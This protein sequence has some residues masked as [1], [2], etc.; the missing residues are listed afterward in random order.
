MNPPTMFC[1]A[2]DSLCRRRCVGLSII[3]GILEI[4]QEEANKLE[5]LSNSADQPPMGSF[6]SNAQFFCT[7][8]SC[9]LENKSYIHKLLAGAPRGAHLR[10]TMVTRS[11]RFLL[12]LALTHVVAAAFSPQ[13]PQ[14]YGTTLDELRHHNSIVT[15]KSEA[16]GSAGGERVDDSIRGLMLNFSKAASLHEK[17]ETVD[18]TTDEAGII[19]RVRAVNMEAGTVGKADDLTLENGSSEAAF[20][21]TNFMTPASRG[22]PDFSTIRGSGA[23]VDESTGLGDRNVLNGLDRGYGYKLD[24]LLAQGLSQTGKPEALPFSEAAKFTE[25]FIGSSVEALRELSLPASVKYAH[26]LP[27]TYTVLALMPSG[28]KSSEVY[29]HGSRSLTAP[30]TS[31]S[32]YSTTSTTFCGKYAYTHSTRYS[33]RYSYTYSVKYS[34]TYSYRYS[35]TYSTRYSYRY[36]YT[37]GYSYSYTYAYTS[38]YTYSYTCSYTYSYRYSY[39]YRYTYYYTCSYRYSYSCSCGKGCTRTCYGT[40]YSTCSG[41]GYGTAYATGYATRYYTCYGR[42]YYTAYATGYGTR[43]A[44]GYGTRYATKYNTAYATAYRTGYATKYVTAYATAYAIKYSTAYAT[45]TC[46]VCYCAA[47]YYS[48]PDGIAAAT[49]TC[50]SCPSG[51][52]NTGE[53]NTDC[54]SCPSGQYQDSSAE[55]SCKTC[56]G[57]STSLNEYRYDKI[58]SLSQSLRCFWFLFV[59]SGLLL[60]NRFS[61]RKLVSDR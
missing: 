46:S 54:N 31:S 40:R 36:S 48:S 57:V 1:M 50:S 23:D 7:G 12:F 55:T 30:S 59:A 5:H 24:A 60:P 43:Y 45:A 33:Y 4:C 16:V 61:E 52:Y 11:Q 51:Q 47:G 49:G 28:K 8:L 20:S 35:Y 21:Q 2:F 26:D 39:T 19:K 6:Y 27:S 56:P 32:C 14:L 29:T 3:R 22:L 42:R 34:Y 9:F 25:N 10:S 18:R 38:Y 58:R 15:D 13:A 41:T 44:T 37:Y 53:G 17:N